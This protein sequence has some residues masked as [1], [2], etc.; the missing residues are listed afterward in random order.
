MKKRYPYPYQEKFLQENKRRYRVFLG[1]QMRLGKSPT[2]LWHR[3]RFYPGRLR[4]LIICPKSVIVSWR[5]ELRKFNE[6]C[7]IYT[8]QNKKIHTLGASFPV[9]ALTNYECLKAKGVKLHKL[10]WDCI[11]L[12]E[13][14]KIRNPMTKITRLLTDHTNFPLNS[15]D[16]K[17]KSPLNNQLRYVLTGT[18]APESELDYF[19]Q[20]KFLFGKM[21]NYTN[22]WDFRHSC[23]YNAGWESNKSYLPHDWFLKG[24]AKYL[25]SHASI[26]TRKQLNFDLPNVYEKRFVTL[27]ETTRK[28]YDQFENDWY[29]DFLTQIIKDGTGGRSVS[30]LS[31]KFAAVAQ[32][33][34]HQLAIGFPKREK[35]FSAKHKLNEL[36]EVMQQVKQDK[37]VIWC[38]YLRDIEEIFKAL[39]EKYSVSK[40]IGG[41]TT[42]QLTKRIQSFHK[43]NGIQILICQIRKASMGMDLSSADTQIFFSRSWSALDNQQAVDR[44]IH[45]SKIRNPHHQGIL[46]ID[47]ISKNTIDE[48]LHLALLDKKAS[49]NVYKWFLKR[50]QE[51]LIQT[52]MVS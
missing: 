34:L 31:T 38:N 36:L 5:E 37:V 29:S 3:N 7:S 52:D 28:V 16:Y 13:T 49:S 9:T 30:Q 39:C 47:I 35:S 24:L 19:C 18:P 41:L 27:D 43:P 1:W 51:Q 26:L 17:Y 45:P 42:D 8:T 25:T 21:G 4:T 2:A 33:Y 14:T 44:L 48:D 6:D 10:P 32:N 12:D 20:F 23:F 15:P 50:T 11:I 22:F 46:T 40:I